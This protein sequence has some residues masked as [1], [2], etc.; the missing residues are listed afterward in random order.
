MNTR[1][2]SIMDTVIVIIVHSQ[3]YHIVHLKN[4][5]ARLKPFH[6]FRI[7]FLQKSLLHRMVIISKL[8]PHDLEEVGSM[9]CFVYLTRYYL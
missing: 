3:L 7:L 9:N 5:I 8:C 4:K 2:V 1:F 6:Y